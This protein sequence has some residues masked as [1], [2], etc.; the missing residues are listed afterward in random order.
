MKRTLTNVWRLQDKIA[1][2]TTDTNLFAFQFTSVED[3]EK[4]VERS[5]WFF[6]DKLLVLKDITGDEQPSTIEF[7]H[8]PMWIRLIDVP[9]NKR[10]AKVM[11][12]IGDYIGG[13]VV[14]DDSGPLGWGE[15]MRI[16]VNIDLAKPLHRG[17]FLATGS[18]SSKWVPIKYKRLAEFCF[19]SGRLDHTESNCTFKDEA[20]DPSKD[21]VF[22]YGPWLRAS[23]RKW[24]RQ[25]LAEVEKEKKLKEDLLSHRRGRATSYNDPDAIKMGPPR[26]ARKS[27]FFSYPDKVNINPP[28]EKE[29]SLVKVFDKTSSKEVLRLQSFSNSRNEVAEPILEEVNASECEFAFKDDVIEMDHDLPTDVEVAV[30]GKK[31]I[32]RKGEASRGAWKYATV[33]HLTRYKSDHLAILLN[34]EARANLKKQKTKRR[35]Y[36]ETCWLLKES[37]EEVIQDSWNNSRHLNMALKIDMVEKNLTE[38]SKNSFD[39]L[40]KQIADMEWA[41]KCAQN[42]HGAHPNFSK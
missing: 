1:I 8:T 33:Q 14:F 2:K 34:T 5:P 36:F 3:K 23:P 25:A 13:F 22:H 17:L 40:G 18:S 31:R 10:N 42:N 26:D 38:W 35:F 19:F 24:S 29:V 32:R 15:F 30:N 16:K 20:K 6:D 41:L 11:K 12:E 27:Q 37:V 4:I 7:T 21:I 28:R 39:N 9:F